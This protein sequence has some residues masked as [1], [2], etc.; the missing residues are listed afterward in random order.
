MATISI[1]GKRRGLA[2]VD[3]GPAQGRWCLLIE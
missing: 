1:V 2:Q 3:A